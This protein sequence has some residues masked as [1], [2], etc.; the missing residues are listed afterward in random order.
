MH[1]EVFARLAQDRRLRLLEEAR[2]WRLLR[3][4]RR[5][6]RLRRPRPNRAEAP[7][8]SPLMPCLPGDR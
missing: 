3:P 8:M 6:R 2:C 1:P 7:V 5:S 4:S